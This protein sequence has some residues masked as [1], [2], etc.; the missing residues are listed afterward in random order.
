[1]ALTMTEVPL[2]SPFPVVSG[3][4]AGLMVVTIIP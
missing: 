3:D 4:S 2:V 1:M